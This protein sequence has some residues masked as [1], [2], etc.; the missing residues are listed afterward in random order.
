VIVRSVREGLDDRDDLYCRW[1]GRFFY[2]AGYE[3][4]DLAQ[5]AR[6]RDTGRR[7]AYDAPRVG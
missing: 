4:E 7:S 3:V 2:A 1:L 5:E 6:P